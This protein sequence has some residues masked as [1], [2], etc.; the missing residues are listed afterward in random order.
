MKQ[1]KVMTTLAAKAALKK[2]LKAQG[3]AACPLCKALGGVPRAVLRSPSA[4]MHA[5]AHFP[6]TGDDWNAWWAT[7]VLEGMAVLPDEWM[8]G[9][10]ADDEREK[11]PRTWRFVMENHK[12]ISQAGIRCEY[13]KRLYREIGSERHCVFLDAD[14]WQLIIDAGKGVRGAKEYH[15]LLMGILAETRKGAEA[16]AEPA[17]EAPK[18]PP[19][20]KAP[21]APKVAKAPAPLEAPGASPS[22]ASA[23]QMGLF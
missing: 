5:E 1:T 12:A 14:F 2:L 17:P 23:R 18:A 7:G 6:V 13:R 19:V 20:P 9:T 11:H 21:P 10:R 15:A 3:G 16:P 4:D 8:T 22:P